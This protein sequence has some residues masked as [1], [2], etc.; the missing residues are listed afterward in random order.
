MVAVH[1]KRLTP[2][3]IWPDGIWSWGDETRACEKIGLELFEESR[4]MS[5]R[6]APTPAMRD[7]Q[8]IMRRIYRDHAIREAAQ[9]VDKYVLVSVM[10][11]YRARLKSE[12]KEMDRLRE[13]VRRYER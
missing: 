10:K 6:Y 11:R 13:M 5:G 12:P 2:R 4:R 3:D 9:A 8:K 1:N 7:H